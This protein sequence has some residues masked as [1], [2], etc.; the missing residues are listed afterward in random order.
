[1]LPLQGYGQEFTYY[2]S[3]QTAICHQ[4]EPPQDEADSKVGGEGQRHA[5]IQGPCDNSEP[6]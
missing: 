3:L 4:G 1:M 5:M 2:P 6:K